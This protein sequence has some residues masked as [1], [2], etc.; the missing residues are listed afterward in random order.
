ME[1]LVATK[2]K[3]FDLI[4]V[5]SSHPKLFKALVKSIA[6]DNF[7]LHLILHNNNNNN[8]NERAKNNPPLMKKTKKNK[9]C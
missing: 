4:M 7:S 5:E 9:I 2:L 1:E 3:F 8:M 6:F